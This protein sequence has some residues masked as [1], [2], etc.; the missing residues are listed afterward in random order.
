MYK[1]ILYNINMP[2]YDPFIIYLEF[3]HNMKQA[4]KT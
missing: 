1:Y 2:L 3:K 4:W